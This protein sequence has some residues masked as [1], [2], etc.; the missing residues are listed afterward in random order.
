MFLFPVL[1]KHKNKNQANDFRSDHII[2][3]AIGIYKCLYDFAAQLEN[4][5]T[6]YSGDIIKVTKQIN[7]D[8]LAG[9]AN[10]KAGQF[11][12]S[13]VQQILQSLPNK[14]GIV[15][16]NFTAEQ[17]GDL[18][19]KKGDIIGIIDN[20]DTNWIRGFTNSRK[21]IFPAKFIKEIDFSFSNGNVDVGMKVTSDIN[22]TKNGNIVD[23]TSYS[24]KTPVP[25]GKALDNFCAQEIDE[26]TISKG[27]NIEL[28]REIDNFWIEG[29]LKGK[30]GKFPR[31]F[32]EILHELPNSLKFFDSPENEGDTVPRAKAT[33]MFV[34]ENT[35]EISFDKGDVIV[36]LE[37]FNKDWMKGKIG[38]S[39]GLFPVNHVKILVDLPFASKGYK[40]NSHANVTGQSNARTSNS[41]NHSKQITLNGQHN[42]NNINNNNNDNDNNDN[43]KSNLFPHPAPSL[44][45]NLVNGS[46]PT[47]QE[48]YFPVPPTFYQKPPENNTNNASSNQS[49]PP[50]VKR[51]SFKK[52]HGVK[53][54]IVDT[55]E[56]VLPL[57][58]L[59]TQTPP[60]I[61]QKPTHLANKNADNPE[62]ISQQVNTSSTP[63]YLGNHSKP[64][65][66]I[67]KSFTNETMSAFELTDERVS[68]DHISD[69]KPPILPRCPTDVKPPVLPRCPTNSKP[70][71]KAPPRP[72]TQQPMSIT[73]ELMESDIFHTSSPV[74][75]RT[76]LPKPLAPIPA[77]QP[78]R[79]KIKD[80]PNMLEV[81]TKSPIAMVNAKS[82]SVS[83]KKEN[84]DINL[85]SESVTFSFKKESMESI[86]S[87]TSHFKVRN[88]NPK[89]SVDERDIRKV[90]D[91]RKTNELIN[92]ASPTKS[93]LSPMSPVRRHTMEPNM[94]KVSKIFAFY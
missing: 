56:L 15:L 85:S 50:E 53:K 69:V 32:I 22:I 39:V 63:K 11:P 78:E 86:D 28:V 30:Q 26:L 60:I 55:Q 6:I 90:S 16:N 10:N 57:S 44:P 9:I 3:M 7:S 68:L 80:R 42:N 29:I 64:L 58:K 27:D 25:W 48:N 94:N 87:H 41:N 84:P 66:D 20:V 51:R 61:K 31:E 17:D 70:K 88:G 21:G 52:K 83:F 12:C 5:L 40:S 82:M 18:S 76:K 72:E 43:N 65:K 2:T 54:P 81:K 75:S 46:L 33:H 35:N 24:K 47:N 77:T 38:N 23:N 36:L 79:E 91:H 1:D 49:K 71:A 73:Q 67:P 13:Y 8:W 74:V 19:I 93:P 89:I 34:G 45:Q 92:L 59:T 4:D 62:G 37:H 14:V